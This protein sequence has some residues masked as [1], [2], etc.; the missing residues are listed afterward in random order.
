[1]STR[2]ATQATDTRAPGDID[3]RGPQFGAAITTALLAVTLLLGPRWG[4]IPLALQA[5][6][7][8]LGALGGMKR[9]PYG[10]LFRTVVAPRLGPATKWEPPAP[11]RFAQ[12]VGLGFALIGLGGGLAGLAPLFYGAVAA[13]FVAALLNAAFGFCLGCEIYVRAARLRS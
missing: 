3:A 4:L 7:F 8:A 11:P 9:Q 1:M 13:A 10:W 5:V 2:V 12:A 6:V